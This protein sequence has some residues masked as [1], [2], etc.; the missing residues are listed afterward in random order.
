[1]TAYNGR[2]ERLTAKE[3]MAHHYFNPIRDEGIMA[4]YLAGVS[5]D[6]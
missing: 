1:M 6:A 2:Q 4:E 3:A 5:K